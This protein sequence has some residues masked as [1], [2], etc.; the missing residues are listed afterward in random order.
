VLSV[1]IGK[2][3]DS[4]FT[5]VS[6]GSDATLVFGGQGAVMITYDV[7]LSGGAL[8]DGDCVQLSMASAVTPEQPESFAAETRESYQIEE[9]DGA[10]IA[11][12]VFHVVEFFGTSEKYNGKTLT[13]T[14]TARVGDQT[15]STRFEVTLRPDT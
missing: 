1:S 7:R 4:G 15:G 10:L 14:V 8:S 6:A 2:H 5:A 11:T 12:E 9:K 13:S 3:S